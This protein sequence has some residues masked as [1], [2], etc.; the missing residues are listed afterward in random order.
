MLIRLAPANNIKS[1]IHAK[2]YILHNLSDKIS[3]SS[4]HI[5]TM[6]KLLKAVKDRKAWPAISLSC[7]SVTC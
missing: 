6:E 7:N 4:T 3:A 5:I 1:S 2:Y